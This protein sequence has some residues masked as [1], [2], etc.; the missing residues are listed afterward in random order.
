MVRVGLLV[1]WF[2]AA[3]PISRS[4]S[5]KATQEGVMRL[6]WSLAARAGA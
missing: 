4:L 5:V 2:L 1:A 3:S 6:P